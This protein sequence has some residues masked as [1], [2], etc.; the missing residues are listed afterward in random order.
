MMKKLDLWLV[1]VVIWMVLHRFVLKWYKHF[2]G[3]Q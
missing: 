3:V 2:I 1:L